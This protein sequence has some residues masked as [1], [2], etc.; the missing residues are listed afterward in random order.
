MAGY[1]HNMGGSMETGNGGAVV[2]LQAKHYSLLGRLRDREQGAGRVVE[3][4][5]LFRRRSRSC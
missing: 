2:K 5:N 4:C 3:L 1:G